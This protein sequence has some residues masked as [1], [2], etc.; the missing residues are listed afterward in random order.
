MGLTAVVSSGAETTS[1][2]PPSLS[3]SLA[4]GWIVALLATI[5]VFAY[6]DVL[7][8]AEDVPRKT[9]MR[10]GLWALVVPLFFA[11][12]GT[13]MFESMRVLGGYF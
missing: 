5:Y 2:V 9:P 7:S 4:V 1:G 6:L 12:T 11:F 10:I 3:V 13:I 8:A